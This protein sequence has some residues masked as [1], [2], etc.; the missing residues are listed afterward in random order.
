MSG[1]P[2]LLAGSFGLAGHAYLDI[3]DPSGSKYIVEGDHDKK[4]DKLLVKKSSGLHFDHPKTDHVS[5]SITSPQV[6]DW[7]PIVLG[8]MATVNQDS[9]T[10]RTLGP[11]SS[12]ALAYILGQLPSTSWF[13]PPHLKGWYKYP[14]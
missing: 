4:T 1:S 14:F 9:L 7:I 5:G 2:L 12:T 6:C 8:A 10:Y 3:V 13:S 11:N